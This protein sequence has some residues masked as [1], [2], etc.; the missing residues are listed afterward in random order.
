MAAEAAGRE[1]FAAP[2]A[3]VSTAVRARGQLS[4]RPSPTEGRALPGG[5]KA[6]AVASTVTSSSSSRPGYGQ[7]LRTPGAWTFL[8]P[9]FAARQPFAMLTVSIVLLVR[10]TTGSYGAAGAV[11]AVTGVSLAL[12]A[13][14]GGRLADRYGQRAVLL[15]GV[16]L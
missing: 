8:L 9:G 4:A 15:P 11:A 6:R 13:P 16:T 1:S 12:F 2:L 3:L 10:H 14:Y 7:L 5:R